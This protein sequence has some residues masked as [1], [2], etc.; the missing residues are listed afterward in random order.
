VSAETNEKAEVRM[1]T[2]SQAATRAAVVDVEAGTILQLLVAALARLQRK[3]RMPKRRG[4]L[5]RV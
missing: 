5:H 3:R 4:R 2:A 1:S